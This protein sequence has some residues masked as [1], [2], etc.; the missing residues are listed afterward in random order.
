[1][2]DSSPKPPQ[3][4][5]SSTLVSS[6]IEF[7]LQPEAA[8]QPKALNAEDFC[9]ECRLKAEKLLEKT[10]ILEEFFNRQKE[11]F[12]PELTVAEQVAHQG[13]EASE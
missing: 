12:A 10:K 1:L 11:R 6:N 3:E 13:K 8:A 4:S 7:S 2:T 9:P 5:K